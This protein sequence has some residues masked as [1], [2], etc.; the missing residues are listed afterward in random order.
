M[1]VYGDESGHLRNLLNGQCDVFVLAIVAGNEHDCGGCPKRA[2]RRATDMAEAKWNEMS[3]NQ[4]RRTLNCFDEADRD[5]YLGYVTVSREDIEELPHSYRIH[6]GRAFRID[7]DLAVIA[8]GYARLLGDI[9]KHADSELRFTFDRLFKKKQSDEIA[10]L[11]EEERPGTE[12]SH[13]SSRQIRG[14]QAADCLAGAVSEM[15]RNDQN[16]F[17][18][19]ETE[20][21]CKTNELKRTLSDQLQY[22]QETVP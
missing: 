2:V 19:F 6:Q 13:G 16:W 22:E 12:I 14:I 4:K 8:H 3:T 11:I 10:A 18:H 17:Q 20:L 7:W 15:Y 9:S 21:H 5:L 1:N